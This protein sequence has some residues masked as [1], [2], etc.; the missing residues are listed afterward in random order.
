MRSSSGQHFLSLDHVR[1]LAALLV[2]EWHFLHGHQGQP[3]PF[4]THTL[5][6]PLVLVDEGHIG[7]A[8]FM[9]LS[10]YLFAKLLDG[11]SVHYG[12]FLWN[13]ALRLLPLLVTIILIRSIEAGVSEGS[14]LGSVNFL[15]SMMRGLWLPIWPN[16]GWSI[17]VEMHFYLILPILLAMRH[18]HPWWLVAIVLGAIAVRVALYLRLGEVQ[19]LAYPTIIGRLDQFTLGIGAFQIRHKFQRRPVVAT[20]LLALLVTV[21]WWFLNQ[22]G[23]F[24]QPSYPSPAPIWLI[25]CTVEGACCAG[26]IA[27]YDTSSSNRPGWMAHL[28]GRMG[29]YS[30]SLYLLHF[31]FVFGVADWIHRHWLDLSNFYVACAV[32]FGCFFLML[33]LGYLSMRFIEG[34]FLKLRRPY[35]S[36][37]A[38][39]H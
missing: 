35:T 33:P 29:E 9:T 17:T 26:L 28:W 37:L 3:V 39:P 5:W 10:G 18:R 32:G 24:R 20:A 2:F 27:W 6:D 19:S 12:Y 16:G 21:Y 30:Y 7:V 11:K 25:L 34:P 23:F 15:T 1:A 22:G 13:R 8:L 4:A 14:W 31:F 38:T 36:G